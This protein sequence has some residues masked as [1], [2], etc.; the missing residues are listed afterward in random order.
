MEG[1]AQCVYC[2]IPE[3]SWGG[4][5]NFHV[6]HYRPKSK[7]AALT[8][9]IQNLFYCCGVC[10]SFKREDWPD[11]PPP[12]LDRPSYPSPSEVDYN[13]LFSVADNGEVAGENVAARYVVE[14]LYL[15]RPHLLQERREARLS[16][17]C[18]DAVKRIEALTSD[19]VAENISVPPEILTPLLGGLQ[20]LI[21]KRKVRPYLPADLQRPKPGKQSQHKSRPHRAK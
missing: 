4:F 7:F 15:N 21:E 6:E 2:A 16:T 19:L 18:E 3:A 8:N 13:A 17:Q 10:N 11:T 14:K 12:A 20:L 9:D 1:R 5:R